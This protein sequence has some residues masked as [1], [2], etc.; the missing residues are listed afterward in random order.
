[1]SIASNPKLWKIYAG[2]ACISNPNLYDSGV[3]VTDVE[4][5]MELNAH[6]SMKF[7]VP[8]NNPHY[9]MVTLGQ[10]ITASNGTKEVFRGR[11]AEVS[12]DFYNNLE[13]YCE[14]QLA[15]FCDSMLQPFAF[16]GSVTE[17]LTL[18]VN[19]HNS[20]VE[21]W[22]QFKLGNVTVTD[23]DNNGV[24]VRSSDSALSCWEIISGRMIDAL[25]G[26]LMVRKSGD[27]YYVDYLKELTEE[28][29]QTVKFGENLLDIEEYIEAE[30]V[31]TVLYPF[32]ARIDQNG[33]N[34]NSADKYMEEPENAG[35]TLWHGNRV[36]VRS[37]N[38]GH[39]YVENATGIA[40]W[41]RIW[42]TNV[43][44]DVTE[45]A[46]LLTKANA[47]LEE[48]IKATTTI[49]LNAVDLHLVDVDIDEIWLGDHVQVTSRPHDLNTKMLCTKLHI[50]PWNPTGNSVTLGTSK[51]SLTQSISSGMAQG[52]GSGYA[53]SAKKFGQQLAANTEKISANTAA[54]AESRRMLNAMQ[55]L[56][57]ATQYAS[58]DNYT[59]AGMYWI[60]PGITTDVPGGQWGFLKVFSSGNILQTFIGYADSAVS[61]RMFV[62]NA[63]TSWNREA[64]GNGNG[65]DYVIHN[66]GSCELWRS[67]NLTGISTSASLDGLYRSN[68]L[69]RTAYP[70]AVQDAKVQATWNSSGYGGFLWAWTAG[71]NNNPPGYY[72]VRTSSTTGISGR[73]DYYVWGKVG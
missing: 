40:K 59:E 30:D 67:E 8:M 45:P 64:R 17:F 62:N 24:L 72:L 18:I 4:I 26:Y 23:P 25:G 5:D 53:E 69:T 71:D 31:V 7:T 48:Q 49:T 9:K 16:K 19:T 29:G 28:S 46:N 47:W 65:W 15:F 10:I 43:W 35:T 42:G 27:A 58:M 14:G 6:G 39:M 55:N 20:Q 56:N 33:T 11:V 57:T 32:G 3:L 50:E 63:W 2:A 60:N 1:M 54:I 44:D 21:S 36:T 22:K 13:V 66:D 34:E 37:V 68:G 38:N 61:I 52:A 51:R 41:G 73:L 70:F 12:K